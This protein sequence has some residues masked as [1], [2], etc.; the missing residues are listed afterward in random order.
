M[1]TRVQTLFETFL[2]ESDH[3]RQA[4]IIR[5]LRNVEEI[6]VKDIAREIKKHATYVSHML[7]VV[8]LPDIVIDG[9]YSKQV[10]F[11]HLIILSRLDTEEEI[12]Q[13]YETVL[14]KALSTART[15]V[16]VRQ[17]KFHTH[18]GSPL[19]SPRELGRLTAQAK[20]KYPQADIQIYQSQIRGKIVIECRGDAEKTGVFLRHFFDQMPA[21]NVDEGGDPEELMI[22]E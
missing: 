8:K 4:Q 20:K 14:S 15:E 13:A 12:I 18:T 6:P 7:R 2:H 3:L 10:S 17:M 5:Q 11:A 21:E 16:L 9:Y 1:N 22:L 19:L